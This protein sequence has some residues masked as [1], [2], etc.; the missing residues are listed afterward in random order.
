MEPPGFTFTIFI[1]TFNR[2]DTLDRAL[3]SVQDQTFRDFEVL[4]IDDGST[5]DTRQL[6]QKW[7][8]RHLPLATQPGKARGP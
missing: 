1:P 7:F 6:I 2:A 4:I 8:P 3:E 5:D